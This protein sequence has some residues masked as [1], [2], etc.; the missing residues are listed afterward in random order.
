ML[1][2]KSFFILSFHIYIRSKREKGFFLESKSIKI[3]EFLKSLCFKAIV[4]LV[5]SEIHEK[6]GGKGCI[7]ILK[8][9]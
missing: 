1:K 2:V 4:K 3:L 8:I 6:R 5:E 7:M 9:F